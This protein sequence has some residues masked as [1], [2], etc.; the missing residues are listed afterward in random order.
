MKPKKQETTCTALVHVPNNCTVL[1]PVP[2]KTEQAEQTEIIRNIRL[3][4][5]EPSP[6]NPRKSFNAEALQE[7]ANSIALQGVLQPITVRRTD[8]GYQIVCGE[9]R[10]RACLLLKKATIPT[11]IKE[12]ISDDLAEEIALI[13]NLHREELTESEEAKAYDFLITKRSYDVKSL[14]E[15]LSKSETYIR[16][17][18]SLLN[19]IP[20]IFAMF[21]GEELNFTMALELSRYSVGIQNE[22]FKEHLNP[23]NF[24]NWLKYSVKEFKNKVEE[25]YSTRLSE[26]NFD[27]T[28]CLT[29]CYNSERDT[30]FSET[31]ACANCRNHE[32]LLQKNCDFLMKK[33]LQYLKEDNTLKV[34]KERYQEDNQAV[35]ALKEIGIS[36]HETYVNYYPAKPEIPQETDF[37]EKE[38]YETA[39]SEY[40]TELREYTED[41][42]TLD[43]QFANGEIERCVLI[44]SKDVEPVYCMVATESIPTQQTEKETAIQQL[45]KKEERFEEIKDEKTLIETK[46]LVS[47]SVIP[48]KK[49]LKP[50]EEELFYYLLLR[51]VRNLKNIGFDGE[52]YEFNHDVK[53][54][55][56][57]NLDKEQK[58]YL[59]REFIV[60]NM[61]E[62]FNSDLQKLLYEFV[63]IHSPKAL[64]EIRDRHQAVFDKRKTRIQEKIKV[65]TPETVEYD[66]VTEPETPTEESGNSGISEETGEVIYL[67]AET[68]YPDYDESE[69][70]ECKNDIAFNPLADETVYTDFEEV[71]INEEESF[72][73]DEVLTA[74]EII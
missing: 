7:L 12:H 33:T 20:E 50:F 47:E 57:K 67:D 56:V 48:L 55:V 37:E 26:Y 29:C 4:E 59:K 39:L 11:I 43:E 65:L 38:E 30:L 1:V 36:I 42:N 9:R 23:D 17:R 64:Q 52:K 15:K 24:N 16:N 68:Y 70:T 27:K 31:K 6:F 41:V 5:I 74:V 18:L 22:I 19:L 58:T 63:E 69:F 3:S 73:F 21:E 14:T 46:E 54:K 8:K 13:E 60:A 40:E 32:C 71:F 62:A 61:R 34:C 72:E 45:T 25:C 53:M 2:Q 51:F 44:K 35:Q 66:E 49:P 10:Y 28:D